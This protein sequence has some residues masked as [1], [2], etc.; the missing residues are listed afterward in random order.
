MRLFE[1]DARLQE[2]LDGSVDEETG[3]IVTDFEE[4]ERL[5]MER[6]KIREGVACHI[7]G[8]KADIDAL[9]AQE[10]KLAT[11]RKAI[12]R[13]VERQTQFLNIISQGVP[14]VTDKVQIKYRAS[15]GKVVVMDNSRFIAWA[16]EHRTDLLTMKEP[17]INKVAVKNAIKSGDEIPGVELDTTPTMSVR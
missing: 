15:Q 4:I 10:H 12:E 2:L 3:E 14:L 8:D 17:E 1:I 6:D 11:R 7:I 5:S 16:K 9:A 13:H